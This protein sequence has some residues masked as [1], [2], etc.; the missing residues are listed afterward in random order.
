[1]ADIEI[2]KCDIRGNFD[3]PPIGGYGGDYSFAGMFFARAAINSSVIC[4]NLSQSS[5]QSGKAAIDILR[6]F[7]A[8]VVKNGSSINVRAGA[9]R[10]CRTDLTGLSR[11]APMVM[12][13]AL[14]SKGITHI[15]GI[16]DDMHALIYENLRALGT[17][18]E[19]NDGSIW[20]WRQQS[21]PHTLLNAKNEP[22]AAMALILLATC[23]EGGTTVRGIDGL[24]ARYP[25]FLDTFSS[26]GGK[27]KLKKFTLQ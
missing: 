20:I 1:M 15:S 21:F 17:R 11:L 4:Q 5:E 7:G 9:L 14:F 8:G 24:L 16:E 18:F 27:Y 23:M 3:A 22:Y 12:L 25:G 10:G 26:L 19:Y 6:A 13:V 2:E